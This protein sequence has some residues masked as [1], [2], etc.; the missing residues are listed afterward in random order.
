[1]LKVVLELW[2]YQVMEAESSDDSIRLA[3]NGHPSVIL[4][5]TPLP[6]DDTLNALS[7]WHS[8]DSVG[9]TP[10]VVLSGYSQASYRQEA[11]KRGAS[12]V[13]VKPIDFD[14][15]R[16]YVDTLV[17]RSSSYRTAACGQ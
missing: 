3:K 4:M 13:L 12:C 8:S 9:H 7:K 17:R 2:D 11:W 16:T 1:M 5:D 14:I 6:F 10:S 15:L